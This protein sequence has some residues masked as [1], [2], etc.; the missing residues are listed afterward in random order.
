MLARNIDAGPPVG[1]DRRL[2]Q[3]TVALADALW[4]PL[5]AVTL[6]DP[7]AM[8]VASPW[9]PP[10][11]DTCTTPLADEVHVTVPVRSCDEPSE[12]KPV[13]VSCRVPATATEKDD[14]ETLRP[15]NTAGLM[16]CVVDPV[17]PA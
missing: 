11:F 8:P 2:T 6:A 5:V 7:L 15:V 12:K 16:V 14:G 1:A 13:A 10:A 9:L 3:G 4:A 17:T